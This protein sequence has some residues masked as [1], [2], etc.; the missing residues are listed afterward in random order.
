M[1]IEIHEPELE[2]LIARR[3]ETGAFQD[4]EDVLLHAL[5]SAPLPMKSSLGQNLVEVCAMVSGLTDDIDFS[6]NPSTGRPL[7][8]A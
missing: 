3:M 1:T 5:K 6:R 8:L 7:D 2:A 4:V